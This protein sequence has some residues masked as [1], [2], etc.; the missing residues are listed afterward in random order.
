MNVILNES[1]SKT[2]SAASAWTCLRVLCIYED[3]AAESQAMHEA[4]RL[5]ENQES[6]FRTESHRWDVLHPEVL[7]N[8][9]EA[10]CMAD[11]II[12]AGMADSELP[13]EV[14]T[15]VEVGLSICGR[16][17]DGGKLVV[18]QRRMNG[19]EAT[20]SHLWQY[21]LDLSKRSGLEFLSAEYGA[22]GSDGGVAPGTESP[23]T[24]ESI[25]KRA[26]AMTPTLVSI[27]T[28]TEGRCRN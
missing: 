23:D 14:Q 26:E 8:L 13:S 17:L 6:S 28:R 12:F 2:D 5:L 18:L 1:E 16:R 24:I 25:Q 27:L 7:A 21:V 20:H 19:M 11:L 15:A 9:R 3:A 4:T 10:V 22:L